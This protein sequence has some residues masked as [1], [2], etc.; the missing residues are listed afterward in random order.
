MPSLAPELVLGILEAAYSPSL[1]NLHPDTLTLCNAALVCSLWRPLAQEVLFRNVT[2]TRTP[3]SWAS[4]ARAAPGILQAASGPSH[5]LRDAGGAPRRQSRVAKLRA[6]TSAI[7]TPIATPR[8]QRSTQSFLDALQI[9]SPCPS[10]RALSL[11]SHVRSVHLFVSQPDQ[12]VACGCGRQV[13]FGENC[14]KPCSA[15]SP[16]S[17]GALT[18]RHLAVLFGRLP[19]LRAAHIVLDRVYSFSPSVIDAL[20]T[21]TNVS[22]LGIYVLK[23]SLPK[24]PFNANNAIGSFAPPA[25]GAAPI[26][27][28]SDAAV[29]Q[30]IYALAPNLDIL[31]LDG[32]LPRDPPANASTKVVGDRRPSLAGSLNWNEDV[33]TE[34]APDCSFRELIWRGKLPPS[35]A[36]LAWLLS[37]KGQGVP[38]GRRRS[39]LEVLELCYLP[40]PDALTDLLREHIPTL[41]SLR[42]HYFESAHIDVVRELLGRD[43]SSALT[44][45]ARKQSS[46]C[47]QAKLDELVLQRRCAVA[48][49]LLFAIQA[50]H[51]SVTHPCDNTLRAL[52]EAGRCGFKRVTV[53]GADRHA[54]EQ[55][56]LACEADGVAFESIGALS[57]VM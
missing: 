11:S 7:A 53:V 1:S 16:L 26:E 38:P 18:E 21:S 57:P 45:G 41:R 56:R 51:V 54:S 49:N 4:A 6:L 12:A 10:D 30:L 27:G 44:F 52:E 14:P 28:N 2:L 23:R 29:F 42:L 55:V 40:P 9:D 24:T 33:T 34:P 48:P 36:L 5:A 46:F 20:R 50:Q 19:S 31:I 37:A 25:Q 17:T 15:A 13:H 22:T 39:R 43:A 32:E 47:P 35:S 8:S 3:E